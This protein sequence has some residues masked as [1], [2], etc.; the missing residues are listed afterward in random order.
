MVWES[1]ENLPGEAPLMFA[2][3]SKDKKATGPGSPI[4]LPHPKAMVLRHNMSVDHLTGESDGTIMVD[5][6]DF[7]DWSQ[8]HWGGQ[9]P[10]IVWPE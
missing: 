2:F 8:P 4:F 1:I 9:K 7:F 3:L 10:K 5:G 6:K